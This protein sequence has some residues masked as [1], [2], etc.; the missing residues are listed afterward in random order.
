MEN[1]N[2]CYCG[3]RALG[4]GPGEHEKRGREG[5]RERDEATSSL[6]LS[7]PQTLLH[8]YIERRSRCDCRDRSLHLA[9]L[10]DAR[11]GP[12]GDGVGG[13]WKSRRSMR[14]QRIVLLAKNTHIRNKKDTKTHER[15]RKGWK[16]TQNKRLRA[17]H[18]FLYRS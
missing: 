8:E 15:Q 1:A 9:V 13:G 6:P 4:E 16:K 3:L 10:V 17:N 12:R 2:G 5:R 18:P 7:L 14:S 11:G